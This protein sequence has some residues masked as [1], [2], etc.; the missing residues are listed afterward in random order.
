MAHATPVGPLYSYLAPDP[1]EWR[2]AVAGIEAELL[3]VGQAHLPLHF[4]VESVNC[5]V[6]RPRRRQQG[7]RP[8][9]PQ[10]EKAYRSLPGAPS[11]GAA[12]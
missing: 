3:L 11:I 8:S 7:N 5:R 6:D 1:G 12:V 10:F 4:E 2:E 9:R